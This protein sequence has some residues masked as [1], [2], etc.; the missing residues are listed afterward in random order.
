MASYTEEQFIEDIRSAFSGTDDPREQAQTIAECMRRIIATGWP[1]TSEKFG[2]DNG[3]YVMHADESTG[4]PDPGF[5]VLAYRQPALRPDTKPAPHDHGPAFVVYGVE[6]GSNVQTRMAWRYADDPSA[7]PTLEVTR[8]DYQAPGHV[9]Y[10][11]P[12][13]IHSTKGSS[14]EETVYVRVTSM[15]LEK[16]KRH[17]YNPE[18]GTSYTFKAATAPR[19]T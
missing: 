18:T 1:E 19:P 8:S 4:H 12:G 6:R 10:F 9:A 17:Y 15:D 7:R 16:V 13:E 2:P 5:M 14:E 11:L 3:V